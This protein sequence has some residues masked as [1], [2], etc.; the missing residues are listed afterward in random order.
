MSKQTDFIAISNEVFDLIDER[1][2]E[3]KT[4]VR[5]TCKNG[6]VSMVCAITALYH[7]WK[8]FAYRPFDEDISQ[9]YKPLNFLFVSNH[10]AWLC[11]TAIGIRSLVFQ[12]LEPQAR[13]L[14]RSFVEATYQTLI[15]FND[16]EAYTTY[17]KGMNNEKSKEVHYE[18]FSKRNR[19]HKRIQALEDELKDSYEDSREA[20]YKQ[21]INMLEHYSQATHSSSLHILTSSFQPDDKD[22][23]QSTILGKVTAESEN[24]LL[25][26]SHEIIYFSIL[27]DHVVRNKWKITWIDGSRDYKLFYDSASLSATFRTY[28]SKNN[29]D[30]ANK[31][32]KA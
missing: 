24:T 28:V 8:T 20:Q 7:A 6:N 29:N 32:N 12:G 30:I 13:V 21:R 25:N 3:S 14:M 23:L 31:N 5:D 17:L 2:N 26:C 18:L 1:K 4:I 9:S 10:L 15:L 11:N 19:L 22:N 16:T 27:F